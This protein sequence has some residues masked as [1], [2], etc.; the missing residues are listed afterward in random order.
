M[1]KTFKDCISKGISTKY[2]DSLW[3]VVVKFVWNHQCVVCHKRNCLEA[4]HICKRKNSLTRWDWRNGIPVCK[5]GCHQWVDTK[6]GERFVEN[7]IGSKLYFEL[8]RCAQKV[9]KQHLVEKGIS[10]N[11]FR[12]KMKKGLLEKLGSKEALQ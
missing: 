3:S 2:L 12:Q 9:L 10:V 4:H 5:F 11:E 8:D 1:K 6:E 7:L